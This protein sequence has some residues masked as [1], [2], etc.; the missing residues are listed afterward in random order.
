MAASQDIRMQQEVVSEGGEDAHAAAYHYAGED[1]EAVT[2]MKQCSKHLSHIEGRRMQEGFMGHEVVR[3]MCILIEGFSPPPRGD[4]GRVKPDAFP[5]QPP[6]T[7][8]SL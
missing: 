2:W 5:P 7:Y 4:W 3:Q 1:E 6:I 8:A